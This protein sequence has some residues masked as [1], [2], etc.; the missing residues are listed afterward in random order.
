MRKTLFY[1]LSFILAASTAAALPSLD[2]DVTPPMQ[3]LLQLNLSKTQL[4]Q[5]NPIVSATEKKRF[6]LQHEYR[7]LSNQLQKEERSASRRESLVRELKRRQVLN[8]NSV[9]DEKKRFHHAVEHLLTQQQREQWKEI[10]AVR[11]KVCRQNWTRCASCTCGKKQDANKV[12]VR[13]GEEGQR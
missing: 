9:R 2:H 6:D 4:Q 8:R 3:S 13:Q 11:Q 10:R 1:L 7:Q 5:I 12:D